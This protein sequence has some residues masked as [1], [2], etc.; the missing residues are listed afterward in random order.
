MGQAM[1][2]G[3]SQTGEAGAD[4]D[5]ARTSAVQAPPAGTD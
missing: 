4:D 3:D 1:S 5:H 2:A